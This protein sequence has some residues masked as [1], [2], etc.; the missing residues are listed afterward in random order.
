[1]AIFFVDTAALLSLEVYRLFGHRMLHTVKPTYAYNIR[2]LLHSVDGI[3]RICCFSLLLIAITLSLSDC[4]SA[5]IFR[6]PLHSGHHIIFLVNHHDSPLFF[7]RTS[8][9]FKTPTIKSPI[10][11]ASYSFSPISSPSLPSLM[12][13]FISYSCLSRQLS[14]YHTH[15]SLL[16]S[17]IPNQ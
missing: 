16:L 13:T 17:P 2:F 7:V 14:T 10:Y 3:S 11:S 4:Q 15:S 12:P 6:H 9:P 8:L 1:V 5:L